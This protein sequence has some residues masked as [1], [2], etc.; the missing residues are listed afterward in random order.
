MKELKLN[1]LK[2]HVFALAILAAVIAFYFLV[3]G[4]T[5]SGNEIKVLNKV[6]AYAGVVAGSIVFLLGPLSRFYP[7]IFS[8]DLRYRK[9]LGLWAF[10]FILIH[11]IISMQLY[12]KWSFNAFLDFSNPF[13]LAFSFGLISFSIFLL[14]ALTST[15]WAVKKMGYK[16]WKV[17]QRTGY[18][19]LLFSA[20]HYA[21]IPG[22]HFLQSLQGKALTLLVFLALSL[23]IYSVFRKVKKEKPHFEEQK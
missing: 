15:L 23:K 10:F 2:I 21:L 7:K 5:Q 11:F 3:Q 18:I 1:D 16:N 4:G 9:P 19:A 14:M 8:H 22:S 13:G 12:Y 17:L 20:I 6:F